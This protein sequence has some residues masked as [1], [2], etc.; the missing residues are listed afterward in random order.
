M[1][2]KP[3]PTLRRAL[4]RVRNLNVHAFESASLEASSSPRCRVTKAQEKRAFCRL[5]CGDH[6]KIVCLS[7]LALP[8]SK[9]PTSGQRCPD[10]AKGTAG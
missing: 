7:R 10:E 8:F 3:M 1:V 4:A 5:L 6:D 2:L 9:G